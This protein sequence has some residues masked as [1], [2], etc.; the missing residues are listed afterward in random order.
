[1]TVINNVYVVDDSELVCK[2]NAA[3][4]SYYD[5]KVHIFTNPNEALDSMK[6]IPPEIILLDYNMPEMSGS[7]FMVKLSERLLSISNWQVFLVTATDF[8]EDEQLSMATLGITQVFSKP[9]DK[10][11]LDSALKNFT[12]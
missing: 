3:L 8:S 1:M 10:N 2:Q 12:A 6:E 4:L 7:E 11:L 9:L 5:F